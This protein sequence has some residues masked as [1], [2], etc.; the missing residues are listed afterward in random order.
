LQRRLKR[1][2]SDIYARIQRLDEQ[3]EDLQAGIEFL[4][5]QLVPYNLSPYPTFDDPLDMDWHRDQQIRDNIEQSRSRKR[6][7]STT[8]RRL[9]NELDELLKV[10][11]NCL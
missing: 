3:I 6:A 11:G 4:E 9:M 2:I 8:R 10:F 7:A 5:A 1:K